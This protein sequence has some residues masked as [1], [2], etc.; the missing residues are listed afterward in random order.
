MTSAEARTNLGHRTCPRGT[1]SRPPLETVK[2]P[3]SILL[4]LVIA[5]LRVRLRR[6]VSTQFH[7]PTRTCPICPAS[8]NLFRLWP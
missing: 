8:R 5:T 4:H 3:F 1:L 6:A 2:A 7:P